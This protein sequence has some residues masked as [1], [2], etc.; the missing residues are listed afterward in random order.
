MVDQTKA[1]FWNLHSKYFFVCLWTL[2]TTV[3]L[4]NTCSVKLQEL[5]N[6]N[7]L[8]YFFKIFI[9]TGSKSNG[10]T[11]KI[12][13]DKQHCSPISEKYFS[14]SVTLVFRF[15]W[16]RLW[17]KLAL[18]IADRMFF[19]TVP[20]RNKVPLVLLFLQIATGNLFSLWFFATLRIVSS[21][22][23]EGITTMAG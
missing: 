8:F 23:L 3:Y 10:T 19:A 13:K 5:C 9:F 18:K 14:S 6:N 11:D 12:R 7:F 16:T 22:T 2:G 1:I 21:A 17:I 15:P 20:Q 4:H